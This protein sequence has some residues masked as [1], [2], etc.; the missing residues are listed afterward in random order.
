MIYY[1]PA[2]P[3]IPPSTWA[4]TFPFPGFHLNINLGNHVL[5]YMATDRKIG[6]V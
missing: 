2:W 6:I 4:F 3:L 5:V 1:F